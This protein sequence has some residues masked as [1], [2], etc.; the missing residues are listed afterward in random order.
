MD[1][2]LG[3]GQ[4]LRRY[5]IAARPTQL[6]KPL[7]TFVGRQREIAEAYQLMEATYNTMGFLFIDPNG[8]VSLESLTDELRFFREQ[9]QVTGP[10]E[11]EQVVESAFAAGAVQKLGRY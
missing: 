2:A 9:G 3:F 6:P 10:V 8:E 1:Q 7:S 5:S 11:V 4:L